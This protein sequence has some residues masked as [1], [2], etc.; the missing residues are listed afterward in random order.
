MYSYSYNASYTV[1]I[2]MH[3]NYMY[4]MK[5]YIR[6]Y[7]DFIQS[8]FYPN[9]S[10]EEAEKILKSDGENGSFLLWLNNQVN[11]YHY[12]VLSVM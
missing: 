2:A 3:C 1:Y 11:G 4:E 9:I 7:S 8:C 5:Y 6:I 10:G 12:Y